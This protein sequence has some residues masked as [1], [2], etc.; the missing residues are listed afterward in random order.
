MIIM[1]MIEIKFTFKNKIIFIIKHENSCSHSNDSMSITHFRKFNKPTRLCDKNENI[2][3][4]KCHMK[5]RRNFPMNSIGQL[6]FVR[7]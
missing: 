4:G 6:I 2:I 5:L 3:Q 7:D 1:C